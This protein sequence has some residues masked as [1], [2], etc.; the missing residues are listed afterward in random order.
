MAKRIKRQV[1]NKGVSEEGIY[2]NL[3][4]QSNFDVLVTMRI[5]DRQIQR[6][7]KNIAFIGEA[8][9]AR[10]RFK[11]ELTQIKAELN[12]GDIFWSQALAQY[13]KHLDSLL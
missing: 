11:S 6:K 3:K 8:R 2:Y 10:D 13:F 12:R 4:F 1:L 5:G 9:H 7:K